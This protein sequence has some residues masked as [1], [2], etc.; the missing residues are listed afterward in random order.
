VRRALAAGLTALALLALGAAPGGDPEVPERYI[1][2][3]EVKALLDLRQAVVF[4]D[5]RGPEQFDELHIAGARN[6]GLRELPRRLADV[7]R[8]E[9]VVLY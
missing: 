4:V 2:V 7:P 5:V 8:K 1:T 6:I 9:L 3:D